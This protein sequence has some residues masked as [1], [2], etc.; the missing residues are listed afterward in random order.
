MTNVEELDVMLLDND[1]D[2][3]AVIDGDDEVEAVVV[4]IGDLLDLKVLVLCGSV[5]VAEILETTDVV[6][7]DCS[8]RVCEYSKHVPLV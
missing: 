2:T 3:D 5:T 4:E 7:L 6:G 8:V 1:T